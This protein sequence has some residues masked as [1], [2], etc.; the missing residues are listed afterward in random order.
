[1]QYER[2]ESFVAPDIAGRMH[3]VPKF[4]RS[5]DL[6]AFM[7]AN[8]VKTGI[9]SKLD[10]I[11]KG[12]VLKFLL[13]ILPIITGAVSVVGGLYTVYSSS[14]C[15]GTNFSAYTRAFLYTSYAYACVNLIMN[16]LLN[17]GT[18]FLIKHA[19]WSFWIYWSQACII[20][21]FLAAM[22]ALLIMVKRSA[23]PAVKSKIQ[24]RFG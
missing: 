17:Q 6:Q 16:V 13:I 14:D 22:L 20:S 10:G 1:M 9:Q 18:L 19:S 2:L 21:M 24:T 23:C 15:K 3:G 12:V 5:P 7:Q 8:A 4:T 11:A